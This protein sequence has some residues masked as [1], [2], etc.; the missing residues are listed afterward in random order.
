MPTAKKYLE[1]A[2][3]FLGTK[4]DRNKF[5]K[6]YWVEYTK[7]YS[8][9]PGTAWCACFQSYVA[10]KCGLKCSYSASAAGFATQFERIPVD[11]E[12][13]V[14][15]GDIVIFNWDGRTSTGWAD[16]VGVV[17]WSTI[18]RDGKFGTIEGNTGSASEGQVLRVTRDNWS[19]YFT[20]FY[21]PKYDQASSSSDIPATSSSKSVMY[22]I[23]VSSN[24]P[25][26]ITA[27]VENDFAIVK[28]SGNPHGYSWNYVNPL[29]KQQVEAA[30]RKHGCVGLYHFTYGRSDANE[31]ADFFVSKVKELGY[32]K[33]AVLVID[34][35]ADALA[36]GRAWVKKLAD[37]VKAK[38]GYSPV[39]YASGGVIVDQGLASL[40]YP[41]WCANY[42]KGYNAIS[43]YSTS[44][45]KIYAG[46]EKS[47][48]WQYTSSGYL[49]GY[50]DPLD[51]NVFYGTAADWKKLAGGS[52]ETKAAASAASST[53]KKA[54]ATTSAKAKYVVVNANPVNVRDKRSSK[55][56][57]VVGKLQRYDTVKLAYLKE[58]S[59][60]NVWAKIMFGKHKG[61]F[62]AVR[63][64]GRALLKK[65][66]TKSVE[67]LAKEV[68]AGKWGDGDDRVTALKAKGY[69]A[70]TVQERVNG[71]LS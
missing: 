49:S 14:K 69:D 6:W 59:A 28:M 52:A 70:S 65:A 57:K 19:S 47:V 26:S 2:A 41:L 66:G 31:E 10:M 13:T 8:S 44:G 4:G 32:L 9:D 60:G 3:S 55:T 42:S 25:S 27:D 45:C 17:E 34:Y 29:A 16:H 63:F 68:I 51:C 67:T 64:N 40:G 18:D 7:T 35:E 5:N 36:M 21:R 56:G 23:D 62:V 53:E 22:G 43:G 24:Q 15:P 71:L 33:K 50:S 37:R 38:A 39:I 54:V 48:L 11:Q 20:A 58:N 12:D 46:C 1:T 30:Y 61:R